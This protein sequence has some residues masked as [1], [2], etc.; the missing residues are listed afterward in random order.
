M[1]KKAY[2]KVS[3][4]VGGI[5]TANA[6]S[7]LPR[8][9]LDAENTVDMKIKLMSLE[10]TWN[11]REKQFLS[12]NKE[13]LFYAYFLGKVDMI[14]ANMLKDVRMNAG[15]GDPPSQYHT[16]S[17]ESANAII[18]RAVS[19]KESEMSSF[20]NKMEELIR[21]QKTDVESAI[22][23]KGPYKLAET[24][25]RFEV[26]SVKWFRMN[27]EQ[28]K[29]HIH[30]FRSSSVS[31]ISHQTDKSS[32]P[33]STQVKL[34]QS[35]NAETNFTPVLS[36]DPSDSGIANIPRA[37]IEG[38][39]R[40]AAEIISQPRALLPAPGSP[41][42]AFMVA[43]NTTK[44]PHFV[45]YDAKSN[46]VTCDDCPGWK[47]LKV[48]GHSVAVAEKVGKLQEYLRW[49]SAKAPE[50]NLT[51]LVTSDTDKGVGKK[52]NR[53]STARR[54]GGRYN[55]K[56]SP[57]QF[58]MRAL[59][60]RNKVIFASQ[61]ADCD[62]NYGLKLIQ[63]TFLKS[64][65]TGLRDDILA[66]NLR[67]MLRTQNLTDEELMKSVNEM[68]SHQIERRN[69]LATERQKTA[70][71]NVCVSE[72]GQ[73]NVEH[74]KKTDASSDDVSRK[75]LA[76]IKQ[77][78]SE[79]SNLKLQ[80][81]ATNGLEVPEA[82][83]TLTKGKTNIVE[84]EVLN[85]THHDI[86]IRERTVMGT[87]QLVQ[88]V[89]PL[90]VQLKQ[91][92]E[93]TDAPMTPPAASSVPASPNDSGNDSGESTVIPQ[94]IK[95]LNLGE[96]RQDQKEIAWKMLAEEADSLAKDDDVIGCIEGLQ[97]SIELDDR[98][99]VQKNYVAVTRPLYPEVKSY[100]A[101]LLN[102]KFIRPSKSSYS[103]PV[104]CVRKKD[105]SLRLCVD[106]RALNKKTIP[107]RH[108]I[109]R[110]QESLDN[111][112][113]NKWF[114]VLDQ[115]KAYHQEWIRPEDQHLTAFTT[116]WGFASFEDHV[117][118]VRKVLRRLREYG[119]KL[120]PRKCALFKKEVKFLGRIVSEEGYKVDQANIEAVLLLKNRAP[121]TVGDVRK[122]MGFLNYYRRYIRNFSRIARPIYDLMSVPPSSSCSPH[123]GVRK[124][125]PK[126]GQPSS[127][128][129]VTWTTSHQ[130][131]LE[132]LIGYLVSPPVM[133]Y[134]NYTDPFILTTDASEDGL[135]AVLYQRQNGITRVIAYGSRSLSPAER[136]YHLH[137]GK[138]EFLALKW[139]ICEQ[140]RDYLYYAPSFT[141][142][143]DN[144]PLTYVLSSAK[145]NASGLRWVGELADFNFC[146]NYRPGKNNNDA[147][148]LSRAPLDISSYMESCTEEVTQDVLKTVVTAIQLQ[149]D[150]RTT[151]ISAI[152]TDHSL[153]NLDITEIEANTTNL[154]EIT[155]VEIR[156]AQRDDKAIGKV[157]SYLLSGKRPTAK[158]VLQEMPET[159]ALLHE[160]R[161]LSLDDDG[162][163]LRSP[164]R[165]VVL[166]ISC[167]DWSTKNYM[168]RWDTS[169]ARES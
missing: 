58:L 63:N 19:F 76:E 169:A 105:Q 61:E 157:V 90:E 18:K 81:D 62:F 93:K 88:S 89:T 122:L 85:T 152:T 96:L 68:A 114:S 131:A 65:E 150:G 102:R 41:G 16:N 44:R 38:I 56:E 165:Q 133:A 33:K 32:Q 11:D 5:L 39:F 139:A 79:L 4:N 113:G 92:E 128:T 159:R 12:S 26:N 27:T 110:I 30:R 107:D 8:G 20:C 51:S 116:P 161:K 134:P 7:D 17:P 137:S 100:I 104:V 129:S 69:K 80:V 91:P 144:N 94:H 29:A 121:K 67:P 84:I 109:P 77:M 155:T 15:L 163:L 158:E 120:K 78:R 166:P 118:H 167:V 71:V 127:N 95:D 101:D 162:V 34:T 36:V 21:H 148:M 23:D 1:P 140:F 35:K 82:L 22:L 124:Q 73:K 164:R 125:N 142:Y 74:P 66:T 57:Q 138:L 28:R 59:D 3:E 31:D 53:P 75:L 119:V 97:M 143:T 154:T 43:S 9:L 108:P 42:K 99:P 168:K 48:C 60:M 146:I 156:R 64:F 106:Y 141:V 86:K 24:H 160:W 111:L 151:W 132:T 153:L 13:P 117:E 6:S 126:T 145:L 52:G 72:G 50:P 46:K 103:S 147:D 10:K 112:G 149:E 55:A 37:S 2:H 40:K 49:H 47:S 135:G 123:K 115:G 130:S 83:L 98:T 54:K 136:N 45:T 70:R 87:L 25:N 14:A